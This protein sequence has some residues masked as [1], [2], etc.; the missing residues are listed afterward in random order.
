MFSHLTAAL[1]TRTADG[2]L[3][4]NKLISPLPLWLL[5]TDPVPLLAALIGGPAAQPEHTR[6]I[7]DTHQPTNQE[8]P[9]SSL[10]YEVTYMKLFVSLAPLLK[11]PETGT[12]ITDSVP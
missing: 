12:A 3:V 8:S 2:L 4:C 7:T 11:T 5:S 6:A 9:C 1:F 10:H